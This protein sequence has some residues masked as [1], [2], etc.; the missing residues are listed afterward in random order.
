MPEKTWTLQC[1]NCEKKHPPKKYTLNCEC[2]N[3]SFLRTN[4]KK[5]ITKQNKN[6]GLFKYID[7]LPTNKTLKQNGTT[8]ITYKS[9]HLAEKLN[10]KNLYISFNGY[11]PEK[12]AWMKTC[13][14]KEL[15]AAPTIGRLLEAGKKSL[16]VASAGNTARGFANICLGE[17]ID[18]YL[19]VPISGLH[20]LWLTKKPTDNIKL[21]TLEKGN[22]YFDAIS[23]TKK[24]A[25]HNG[26]LSEGGA[27]NVARRDGMGT[28]VVDATFKIGEVPDHYFQAV[29]SGTGGIAAWEANL[30]FNRHWGGGQ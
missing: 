14:F 5:N 25:E 8:P 22:D 7:W 26:I 16:I 1:L 27:R 29:G 11:W 17:D 13:S 19:V 21:I 24:I 2:T 12:G 28:T 23:I 18:L 4:Y 9:K 30:R 20:N 10:L 6:P 15:E 3:H